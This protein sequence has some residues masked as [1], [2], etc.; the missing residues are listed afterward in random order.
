MDS[1]VF[2]IRFS[3]LQKPLSTLGTSKESTE[4]DR[5]V[6][7]RPAVLPNEHFGRLGAAGHGQ[8]ASAAR[9]QP[10]PVSVSIPA[11]TP[12]PAAKSLARPHPCSCSGRMPYFQWFSQESAALGEH[13]RPLHLFCSSTLYISSSP[14][15]VQE[16]FPSQPRS[17]DSAN[18]ETSYLC[19]LRLLQRQNTSSVW[20]LIISGS[21]F[22]G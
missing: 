18:S 10:H 15:G 4:I 19:A 21:I 8:P 17:C 14:W 7:I 22:I 16:L 1:H 2:F 13:S 3:P 12:P 9:R 11:R 20:F 5:S 6:P